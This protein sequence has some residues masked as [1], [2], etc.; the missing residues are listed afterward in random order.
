MWERWVPVAFVPAVVAVAHLGAQGSPA[1]RFLLVPPL[2]VLA[3]RA[4]MQPQAP[5][6]RFASMVVGPTVGALL[7]TA[8]AVVLGSGML[9][10][11]LVTLVMVALLRLLHW[12]MP[13]TLAIS[14][15]PLVLHWRAAAYPLDVLV[16]TGGL[17]LTVRVLA[18]LRRAWDR[19][20]AGLV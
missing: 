20:T 13:P 2:A 14:L 6:T 12:Q 8:A 5:A 19:R 1:L 10:V 7:G 17:W 9:A 4:S 18:R 16:A 11:V 15:L 3:E